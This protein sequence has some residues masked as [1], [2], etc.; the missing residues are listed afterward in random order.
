MTNIDLKIGET[1]RKLRKENS[2]TQT[3]LAEISPVGYI[4]TTKQ[5]RKYETGE[6]SIPAQ[7]LTQLLAVLRLTPAEFYAKVYGIDLQS[8][9]NDFDIIWD[10]GNEGNFDAF[11]IKLD[12]LKTKPYCNEEVPTAKQAIM[13]CD[14]VL[15][16]N[17]DK[18]YTESINTLINAMN[19]TNPQLL[20]STGDIDMGFSENIHFSLTEYRILFHLAFVKGESDNTP[21]SISL[22]KSIVALL[23]RDSVALQTKKKLLPA[24]YYNLS[25]TMIDAN[26]SGILD[27]IE[28]GLIFCKKHKDFGL[29]GNLLWNKGNAYYLIGDIPNAEKF[30]RQS[31]ATFTAQDDLSVVE[32]LRNLGKNKYN[33]VL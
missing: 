14:S 3:E 21:A 17:V 25:C 16:S 22:E 8:F 31:I 29:L 30:F 15:L 9:D 2:L 5:F 1:L 11:K 23:E 33:V 7:R 12:E 6:V 24:T 28:R 32:H 20:T 13:L 10:L 4:C 27:T 18:K 26:M 19:I